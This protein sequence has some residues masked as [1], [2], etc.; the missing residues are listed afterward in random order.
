MS[1][2]VIVLLAALWG[3]ILLPGLWRERRGSDPLASINSFER[4]MHLLAPRHAP[5]PARQQPGRHVMVLEEPARVDPRRPASAARLARRRRAVLQWLLA[6]VPAT[7]VVA[8][9]LGGAAWLLPPAAAALYACYAAE[10]RRLRRR[11]QHRSKLRR[12]PLHD[13]PPAYDVRPKAVGE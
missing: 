9:L 11:A 4:C 6:L 1:S 5:P 7:A 3:S 13:T 12:L 8:L 2:L 10:D